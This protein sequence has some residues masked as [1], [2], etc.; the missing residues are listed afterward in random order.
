M[1]YFIGIF[2]VFAK[3]IVIKCSLFHKKMAYLQ[4]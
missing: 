1:I 2:F 4:I 3:K